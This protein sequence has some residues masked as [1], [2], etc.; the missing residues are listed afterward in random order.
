M[1]GWFTPDCWMSFWLWLVHWQSP[2]PR[3]HCQMHRIPAAELHLRSWSEMFVVVVANLCFISMLLSADLF[4][5]TRVCFCSTT[6]LTWDLNW[7][8]CLG[9]ELNSLERN[10]FASLTVSIGSGLEMVQLLSASNVFIVAAVFG[11]DQY[12]SFGGRAA[13]LTEKDCWELDCFSHH[14]NQPIACFVV[15]PNQSDFVAR[16]QCCIL[17]LDCL[18]AAVAVLLIYQPLRA[19]HCW[20]WRGI[21]CHFWVVWTDFVANSERVWCTTVLCI[22]GLLRS[23]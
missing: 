17:Y 23:T 15:D 6:L 11:E 3:P 9:S 10:L 21:E 8:W 7:S 4:W 5:S 14:L 13:W 19:E 12:W 16:L 2:R 20:K 22:R 1:I 18:A